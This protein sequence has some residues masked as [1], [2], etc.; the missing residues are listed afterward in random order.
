MPE[1]RDREF[2]DTLNNP[3]APP[4]AKDYAYRRL[5]R[6]YRSGRVLDSAYCQEIIA[7]V[8]KESDR[9]GELLTRLKGGKTS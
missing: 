5:R 9:R 2:L 3:H 8:Q 4:E 6:K 1:N 7:A